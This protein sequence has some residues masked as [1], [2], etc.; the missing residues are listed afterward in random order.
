MYKIIRLSLFNI[1][2]H[3]IETA[4]LVLLIMFCMLLFTS[5][6]TSE[7]NIKD[8]FPQAM[9][10]SQSKGNYI[11]MSRSIFD[12]HYCEI[13]SSDERVHDV[14]PIEGLYTMNSAFI[15]SKGEEQAMYMLFITMDTEKKIASAAFESELSDEQ[16]AALEHPVYMPFTARESLGKKAGDTYEVVYG[17]KRFE[18]TIAGFFD[19]ILFPE[20]NGGL[21]L[22]VSDED[23]HALEGVL[24]RYDG[25][26]FDA[27]NGACED[28]ITRFIDECSDYSGI[29]IGIRA[30]FITSD[31]LALSSRTWTD[32]MTG[33][34]KIMSILIA[35]SAVLV[36][37]LRITGDIRDQ[38]VAIGVLEALGY[39]S[40]DIT[41]SYVAEYLIISFIGCIL[42]GI[43]SLM[44]SPVLFRLGETMS[45]YRGSYTVYIAPAFI[46]AA[47]ICL[48]I[49]FITFIRA[50]MVRKYPPVRAFRK[51]ISDHHFRRDILPLRDTKGRV[52]L[53]FAMKGF[54]GNLGQSATI[55]LCIGISAVAVFVA[56]IF[57]SYF[58]SD[59]TM[60]KSIAG[61]EMSEW[62]VGLLDN[63]DAY[64]AAAQISGMEGVRKTLTTTEITEDY[65]KFPDFN[66]DQCFVIAYESFDDTENIFTCSGRFPEHDN[67]IMLTKIFAGMNGIDLGDTV[68]LELNKA[69]MDFVVT[70]F[71][72]AMTNGGMNLY[73][74]HAGLKSLDPNWMP[75]GIDIYLESGVDRQAFK[76][77]LTD[78]YGRSIADMHKESA[79]GQDGMLEDKIRAEADKEIAE[80]I[81]MYGAVSVEYEIRS[82]DTVVSGSSSEFMISSIQSWNDVIITQLANVI[83][84]VNG[85]ITLFMIITA[86]VVMVIIFIIM[87][88]DIRKQYKELGVMLSLGYTS[89]E[90]MLQL[91]LRILPA[92]VLAVALGAAGNF[93][94]VDMLSKLVGHMESDPAT[95]IAACIIIPVFCFAC[96]YVGARKIKNISVYELITE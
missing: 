76:E 7:M 30:F 92:V 96:A 79:D 74:T 22:I 15:N 43:G 35:V 28:I 46:I 13:L 84:A 55:T 50:D 51:G 40:V 8:I 39:K 9:E 75:K 64:D 90:L 86:I 70:G 37:L 59:L 24:D 57:R 29:D 82:G 42:G 11:L 81:S 58:S 67:E 62:H 71:V 52:H 19:T 95:V 6:V 3:K 78:R 18:F 87:E 85:A 32:W 60:M 68:T 10:K 36:I 93:I 77:Q 88:Q 94:A 5:A 17:S 34:M 56:L 31:A 48:L 89:H 73:M 44:M 1:R 25:I 49:A 83:T 69:R 80:M 26:A 41:L 2:K 27:D 23:Y 61:M 91:A 65:V 53:R 54:L 72:S 47:V 12:D 66:N 4:S 33:M 38:I 21:K 63:I 20:V 16:I 14:V 45:G